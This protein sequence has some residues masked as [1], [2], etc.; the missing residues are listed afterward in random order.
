MS[1]S[2]ISEAS[3]DFKD[4]GSGVTGAHPTS[5]P[6]ESVTGLSDY[7]FWLEWSKSLPKQGLGDGKPFRRGVVW[8]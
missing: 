3:K 4:S 2:R 6:E 1:D 8:R 5:A 7:C